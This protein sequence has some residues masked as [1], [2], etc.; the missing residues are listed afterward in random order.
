MIKEIERKFLVKKLPNLSKLRCVPYER[1]FL[2]ITSK[3][4]TRIQRK[5]ENY[6]HEKK[7][8]ESDLTRKTKKSN[9][10]KQEFEKF[11]KQAKKSITRDSYQMSENPDISIKIYHGDYEGLVR[12]EVEFKN[13]EEARKFKP[14]DWFGKE[15]TGTPLGKDARLIN[16]SKEEFRQLLARYS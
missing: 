5:G 14:L 10:S 9:I 6:E 7:F 13:E 2:E 1:Y 16:L 12:A 15:I 3:S 8:V 4:E 11:K